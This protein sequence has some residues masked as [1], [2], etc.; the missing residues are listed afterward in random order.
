MPVNL[1]VL[2][3]ST[4]EIKCGHLTILLLLKSDCTTS[5]EL[6]LVFSWRDKCS[7]A[8]IKMLQWRRNQQQQQKGRHTACLSIRFCLSR[9]NITTVDRLFM[10][11]GQ[12]Q[13]SFRSVRQLSLWPSRRRWQ[14]AET[15]ASRRAAHRE[16]AA[17]PYDGRGRPPVGLHR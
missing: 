14:S 17:S 11:A 1:V 4:H 3:K 8:R 7:G 13:S 16:S 5:E 15:A 9:R 12:L 10:A 2:R 6:T